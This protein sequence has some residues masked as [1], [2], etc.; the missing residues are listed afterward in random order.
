MFLFIVVAFV[1]DVLVVV[2]K[3]KGE[4]VGTC[5]KDERVM[6]WKVGKIDQ[7]KKKKENKG[8][9]KLRREKKKEP[10]IKAIGKGKW[11]NQYGLGKKK[12]QFMR[13]K[14]KIE[15]PYFVSVC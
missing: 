5:K 9:R 14:E 4:A 11:N 2:L 15:E 13:R 12:N 3:K 7:N 8:K 1:L 6:E 10:D